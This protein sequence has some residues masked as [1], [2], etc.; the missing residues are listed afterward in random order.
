MPK[1]NVISTTEPQA[2]FAPFTLDFTFK[3]AFAN[4]QCK[5]LLIFMLNTFLKRVLKKPITDVKIIHT[6]LVG[7]T[8]RNRGVVFDM[9]CE[10]ASGARFIVEMQVEEQEHFIKRSLFYLCVAVANLA[11][12]G[13]MESK[14]K[15]IPYDYNIPVI[16]T[17]SFLSFDSDFG[18]GC[19]EVVQYISL[20]NELHPKVRYNIIR[21]VYVHLSKFDKT[22]VECRDDLDQ[23]LFAFKNA[24]KLSKMPKSFNKVEFKRLFDIA[25]ISNFNEEELMSYESE[26][27][28]FSDHA[29]ALAYAKKKGIME[30]QKEGVL[31]GL[32]QGIMQTAKNMLAKGYSIA[33]IVGVTN[34]SR[35]QVKALK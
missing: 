6:V 13:K 17:L 26:M 9:Q 5:D 3:K 23:L 20:S 28:R 31:Q 35:E 19:N 34:L 2:R 21:M 14:G 16:Y 18:K 4:E 12:K 27:K 30:G 7:K 10:D 24:H 25:Q 22:E 1:K 8:K 32:A 29:N 11:K 15:K 33:D